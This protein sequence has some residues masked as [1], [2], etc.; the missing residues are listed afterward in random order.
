[1][2]L[3]AK[4]CLMRDV[5]VGVVSLAQGTRRALD[6]EPG[7]RF[8]RSFTRGLA[9]GRSEPG[10]MPTYLPCQGVDCERRIIAEPAL[11]RRH[12]VRSRAV[13]LAASALHESSHSIAQPLFIGF[14]RTESRQ[15]SGRCAGASTEPA[16]HGRRRYQRASKPGCV[17]LDLD[18]LEANHAHGVAV[19]GSG[20]IENGR[21]AGDD[22]LTQF[23]LIDV[24]AK[25]ENRQ[26]GPIMRML[27]N[28]G[29]ASVNDSSNPRPTELSQ[30]LPARPESIYRLS[31]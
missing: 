5:R 1:M 30:H 26:H 2:A 21:G 20:L 15:L 14:H 29:I 12:P 31:L 22:G 19:R 24:V 25:N 23:R 8:H 28:A 6:A 27:G 11:N 9:I 4:P 10:R 3:I 13:R 7:G 17:K 16:R 18:L